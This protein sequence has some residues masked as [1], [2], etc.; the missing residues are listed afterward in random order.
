[1]S[2]SVNQALHA[3]LGSAGVNYRT[4]QHPPT[5][6]SAESASARGE[7]LKVGGKALVVKTGDDFRLFVLSAARSLDSSAVKRHFA[8]KKMR[9]ADTAELDQLTGLVP[10]SV[11]PFGRP[12]LPLDLFVDPSVLSNDR[13]AFN[14]GLLTES[15]VMPVSDYVRVA[16]PTVLE[17]AGR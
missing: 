14:A 6:T 15:I 3:L 12:I 16:V 11:P 9:F 5:L 10:G 1:M 7:D 8:V 13:I 17:F 4:I 2:N